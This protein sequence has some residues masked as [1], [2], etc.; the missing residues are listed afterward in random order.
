MPLVAV[1]VALASV[2]V[3]QRLQAASSASFARDNQFTS[4]PGGSEEIAY[5]RHLFEFRR[6]GSSDEIA[7][8]LHTTVGDVSIHVLSDRTTVSTNPGSTL[9]TSDSKEREI[10]GL[11][12]QIRATVHTSTV[13]CSRFASHLVVSCLTSSRAVT[14][15]SGSGSL[16]AFSSAGTAD[17]PICSSCFFAFARSRYDLAPSCLTRG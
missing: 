13:Y 17:L 5:A 3:V 6:K 4:R 9:H 11:G 15:T 14:L 8:V 2:W 12:L 16:S 10:C 7:N 1:I